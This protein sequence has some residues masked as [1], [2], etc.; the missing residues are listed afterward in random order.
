V[1]T[2]AAG[3]E[4]RTSCGSAAP[5]AADEGP[6]WRSGRLALEDRPFLVLAELTR[7]CALACRHC[8]ADATDEPAPG[9][10]G[11]DA[12]LAVLDDLA[13]LGPPRPLVVLTGGDPLHREDAERLVHHGAAQGLRMAVSPAGTPRATPERLAALRAA[14]A[15]AVSFSLDGASPEAHDAFRGVEGSFAWTVAGALAARRIGFRLQVNT[16]VC[17]ETVLELPELLR[18]VLRLEA[19][20]WSVFLL[21]PTGRGQ[22]LSALDA[23]E[24]EDVLCFL[25]DAATHVPLKT[26]EAPQFRRVL[27]RHHGPGRGSCPSPHGELYAELRRR[28]AADG[29][30]GAPRWRQAPEPGPAL[31]P[32]A[33]PSRHGQPA[34][35]VRRPLA[36]GDGRGVVFVSSTGSIEPSGFLPLS[37]GRVTQTPLSRAY[38]SAPLLRALRDPDALGGRCGRCEYRAVCGGSRAQAYARLG[39]PLAEDPSCPYEPASIRTG[40]RPDRAGPVPTPRPL[41]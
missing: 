8:R 41:R 5:C 14:G 15:G 24:T 12:W 31:R 1:S 39:D 20:L 32:A 19:A 25:A 26:T 28:L 17:G 23:S 7:A 35:A 37:V 27:G 38:A 10:L 34:A 29:P 13:S 2:A 6:G 9:E 16:T 33:A 22:A 40:A 4:P 30:L 11:T 36:V 21:V 3:S 18:I